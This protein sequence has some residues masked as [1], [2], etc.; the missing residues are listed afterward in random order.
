MGNAF[1]PSASALS[2][3]DIMS[4]CARATAR[5]NFVKIS[6]YSEFRRRGSNR[7]E[8]HIAIFRN[9]AGHQVN[10]D[11]SLAIR[12]RLIAGGR[13]QDK[14]IDAFACQG[15]EHLVPAPPKARI[16]ASW[17]GERCPSSEV[18]A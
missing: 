12:F 1:A 15:A 16:W 9:F 3:S 6:R 4:F 13:R 14:S 18:F 7:L 8:H 17:S 10:K 2:L 11:E 5:T